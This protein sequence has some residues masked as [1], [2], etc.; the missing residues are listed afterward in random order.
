MGAAKIVHLNFS[1]APLTERHTLQLDLFGKSDR[2]FRTFC[3]VDINELSQE[4]LIKAI[5][6][7]AIDAVVDLRPI[8][9]FTAPDFDHQEITHWLSYHN[10]DYIEYAIAVHDPEGFAQIDK[11]YERDKKS[12]RCSLWIYDQN[13]KD[14]GWFDRVRSALQKTNSF[15][16]SPRS[17]FHTAGLT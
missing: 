2:D 7:G 9:V 3:L 4:R 8:P 12:S 10:V 11:Q 14:R 1:S 15:E 6:R 5:M 17:L 13:S 16:L